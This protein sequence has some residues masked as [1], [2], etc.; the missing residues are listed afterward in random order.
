M[1]VRAA[2]KRPIRLGRMGENEYIT[3]SF[4]VSE[5]IALYPDDV[6][7]TLVHQRYGDPEAYPCVTVLDGTDLLWQINS[8][9][10]AIPGNGHAELMISSGEVLAKSV[11]FDTI[12]ETALLGSETPPDPWEPWVQK[13]QEGSD[14]IDNLA[15]R[16]DD[17][18]YLEVTM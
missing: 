5:W 9:D 18:G 15:F 4:D 13:M 1:T 3:V 8:A 10:V 11:I 2:V 12:T 7:F 14:K 6:H 17:N 16:I